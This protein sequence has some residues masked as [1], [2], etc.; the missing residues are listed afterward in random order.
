M[1]WSYIRIQLSAILV[2]VWA[3]VV[4]LPPCAGRG[5]DPAASGDYEN[6][7]ERP[8]RPKEEWPRGKGPGKVYSPTWWG[9]ACQ[10]Q[11]PKGAHKHKHL[12]LWFSGPREGGF[13][14]PLFAGSLR[15]CGRPPGTIGATR[16]LLLWA[17]PGATQAH[18][19]RATCSL[20][21]RF[22]L[23][24]SQSALYHVYLCSIAIV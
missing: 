16:L 21:A 8:W 13:Q 15:L 12:L 2:A 1:F 17:Q 18:R 24:S 3:H 22:I 10:Q 6:S 14:K 9:K 7:C 23:R 5:R 11:G 20:S 4:F 19:C